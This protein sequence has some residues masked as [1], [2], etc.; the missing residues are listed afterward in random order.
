MLLALTFFLSDLSSGKIKYPSLIFSFVPI[1]SSSRK[2][3]KA[4]FGDYLLGWFYNDFKWDLEWLR[5]YPTIRL[6][7]IMQDDNPFRYAD[8]IKVELGPCPALCDVRVDVTFPPV[9]LALA[10]T[11]ESH[12]LCKIIFKISE[13]F[14]LRRIFT[15]PEMT[16]WKGDFKQSSFSWKNTKNHF[17]KMIIKKSLPKFRKNKKIHPLAWQDVLIDSL[18]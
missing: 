5:C 11:V 12:L 3:S 4:K 7:C 6:L 14:P 13:K 2:S 1:F 16:T 15:L 18:P 17:K 10:L 9:H 8:L